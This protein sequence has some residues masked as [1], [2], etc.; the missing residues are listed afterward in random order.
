MKRERWT[1]YTFDDA[2]F[3]QPLKALAEFLLPYKAATDVVQSDASSLSDVHQQFVALMSHVNSLSST[4]Y[5]SGL[6]HQLR[7]L[8]KDEWDD[9]VNTNAV[10]TCA[11]F[12]FDASYAKFSEEQKA[13]ARDW[14][15]DWGVE[16]LRYYHLS[17]SDEPSTL[18]TTIMK[19]W[20]NFNHRSGSFT[21]IQSMHDLLLNDFHEEE[22]KKP[23]KERRRYNARNTWAMCTAYELLTLATA[24]LSIT[25][26][27]AAVERSFSRQGFVH[28]K[29]RN[30]LSDESVQMQMFF[31]FN[32]RALEQPNRHNGASCQDLDGDEVSKV[33]AMLAGWHADD[34]IIAAQSDEEK[35]EERKEALRSG[36]EAA[37]ELEVE[38]DAEEEEEVKNG[39]EE[40][41]LEK[42]EEMSFEEKL[43]EFVVK[44]VSD[45]TIVRGW[46]WSSW[47]KQVLQT[48]LLQGGIKTTE[49]DVIKSINEFIGE[50]NRA[51]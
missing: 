39:R 47:R 19:Q 44:Y 43:K 14:F 8:I 29:L 18:R 35:V 21:K 2:T 20:S 37:P 16:Y 12:S 32:T 36:Q 26:S 51:E 4:H 6:R 41:V 42:K 7:D 30:R 3:W 1:R 45:N 46:K 38:S 28:S 11:H 10:V 9:H 17:D 48:A 24:L 5:L 49:K 13:D 15:F 27:E 25:A 40:K 23:P 33:T 22:N 31:S 50:K 34:E